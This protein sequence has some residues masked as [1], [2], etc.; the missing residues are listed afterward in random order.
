MMIHHQHLNLLA[1]L[2]WYGGSMA[3]FAKSGELI[4]AAEELC[5]ELWHHW[6]VPGG[7]V[8]LG[9][10]KGHWIFRRA[11]LKN[12]RRIRRL[13]QPR[14]WQC[15]RAVFY[16]MLAVMISAGA[17]LSAWAQGSYPGLIAVA[18]LDMSL[19]VGLLY[20]SQEFWKAW[21]QAL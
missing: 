10:I 18:T 4:L 16:L 2:I 11:C 9:G 1:A 17:L 13:R 5:P 6:L 21:P 7:G 15:Y 8:L 3:L 14:P 20:G 19:A 12:R